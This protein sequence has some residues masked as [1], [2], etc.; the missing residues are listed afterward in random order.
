MFHFTKLL[1]GSVQHFTHLGQDTLLCPISKLP[2]ILSL[3]VLLVGAYQ[4]NMTLITYTKMETYPRLLNGDFSLENLEHRTFLNPLGLLPVNG[5]I[6]YYNR[7][8]CQA[9]EFCINSQFP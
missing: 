3:C 9:A 6:T 4:H 1:N 2:T 7:A 8:H 5:P